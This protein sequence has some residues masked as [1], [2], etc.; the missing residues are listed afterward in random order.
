M[1]LFFCLLITLYFTPLLAQI[2]NGSFENWTNNK[3]QDWETRSQGVSPYLWETRVTP[4]V[5][6]NCAIKSE[7]IDYLINTQAGQTWTSIPGFIRMDDHLINARPVC[8]S[9]N[10]K[11]LAEGSDSLLIYTTFKNNG[12]VIGTSMFTSRNT[13]TVQFQS[14]CSTINYSS[15]SVPTSYSIMATLNQITSTL[16]GSYFI[17]DN[18]YF[19]SPTALASEAESL[20][21]IVSP[22]PAF[23]ELNVFLDGLSG[24]TYAVKL[25]NSYGQIVRTAETSIF[26]LKL[27]LAELPAG[28]YY[29]TVSKHDRL[30][31]SCKVMHFY[32]D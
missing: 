25:Q 11:L 12:V 1:K 2:P 5:D 4:A 10:Y 7:K 27:D 9:G 22:N 24:D 14:F 31:I 26:P 32:Y 16:T 15:S 19:S 17:L 23:S 8:I 29:I 18:I 3:V 6:G 13:S 21:F 28:S 20:S 30:L